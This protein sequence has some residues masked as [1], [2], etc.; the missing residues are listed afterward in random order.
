[1]HGVIND[2]HILISK[3]Q[4]LFLEDY[5]YHKIGDYSIIPQ[6]VIDCNNKFLDLCVGMSSRIDSK[7]VCKS[8]SYWQAQFHGLFIPNK[9]VDGVLPY[10]LSDKTYP[11]IYWIMMCFK[12]ER[13]HLILELLYNRKHILGGRLVILRMFL[14]F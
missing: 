9:G 6:I 5:Y 1:V 2:T 3:P 11:L 13:Q 10:L 12:K 4:T 8:T 7:V 14:A